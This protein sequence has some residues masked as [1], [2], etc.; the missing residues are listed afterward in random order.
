[1][2]SRGSPGGMGGDRL[3]PRR[4]LARHRP[5]ALDPAQLRDRVGRMPGP[6]LLGGPDPSGAAGRWA[7]L[8]AHPR[9]VI[10]SPAGLDS[11][12]RDDRGEARSGPDA[13]L[14]L[15][16][17]LAR[18]GLDRPDHGLDPALPFQGGLIGFLSYDLA[19]RIEHTPR[20]LPV[21][22][23][24]PALRFGLYDTFVLVD[25]ARARA[26]LWAV[27]LF[28]QGDRALRDRLDS[29]DDQL[30]RPV[31]PVGEGWHPVEPVEPEVTPGA[32]RA[33]VERARRYIAAGDIFQV[34][35]AQRFSAAARFDPLA[36]A[37]RL[38]AAS[39]APYSAYLA[40]D[41]QAIISVSPELFY[42][43]AGRRIV[44]R[45]IKGT[46]P[47]SADPGADA[48]EAAALLASPKDAAELTMIVDLERNDL[49]RV[50][51]FGSVRV[52]DP[53]ALESY[54][55]VHHT[56]A[57]IEGCLRADVAPVNVVRALFPGGSIT[58]APK[59]RAMQIIDELEPCRRGVYTGAIGY[60]SA[61]DRSAFNIAIRTVVI[62]GGRVGYHVGGGIV[63]DS[64]PEAE[65]RETLHKGRALF[66]LLGGREGHP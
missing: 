24:T 10:E 62:E 19:P 60:W 9:L 33:M 53:R 59:I 66:A 7:I 46:R 27:D 37:A 44:T 31:L 12:V 61:N 63:A 49:G 25:H 13:L 14:E 64:D 30:R 47:R 52:V 15:A 1:M 35:L 2:G 38:Q 3:Q 57:T 39:P 11:T 56:V 26:D 50:C 17:L 34:N 42:E 48:A 41:D 18:H 45:P 29:W 16:A 20:R 22:P 6:A 5:L 23:R 32:Y 54:P 8:A 36:L 43:T 40:W 21:G 4:I 55:N 58:G 28:G 65:Y 51:E